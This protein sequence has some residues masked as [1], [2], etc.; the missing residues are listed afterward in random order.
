[1]SE[2]VYRSYVRL[3]RVKGP[4]RKAWLP[5]ER[6]PVIFGVHGA[7]AEHYKVQPKVLEPHATTLDYI[8]AAA[9]G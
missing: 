8:V 2:V 3:E 9:A 4:I 5:A 6:D 7:V 1:M